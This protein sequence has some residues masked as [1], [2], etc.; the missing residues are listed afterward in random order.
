MN[1]SESPPLPDRNQLCSQQAV[2]EGTRQKRIHQEMF[3]D[4]SGNPLLTKA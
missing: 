4:S 2:V 1:F 3:S